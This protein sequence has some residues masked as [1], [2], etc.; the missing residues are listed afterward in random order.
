MGDWNSGYV[1][2]IG[3]TYGSYREL[4]P[5]ILSFA[6]LVAGLAAPDP[7]EQL[8]YCELGCGQG[9]SA[10]IAAAGNPH[11]EVYANDFN[12]SHILG[13]RSLAAAA[14]RG[15]VHFRDNSFAECVAETGLPAFDIIALHGIYSWISTENRQHIVEFIRT[16]LKPGGLVYISYNTLPGWSAAMPLRRLMA[17]YAG[18][19]PGSTGARVD[20]ALTYTQRLVDA[21][22][23]YFRA[24]PG[25]AEQFQ[26]IKGQN[27]SYLAHEYFNR[28]WTPFHHS[29]VV[30]EM[31]DAKLTYAG[32]AHLLDRLDVANFTQEQQDLLNTATSSTERETLRD[33]ILN[34]RFRRDIFVKGLVPLSSG[35][36]RERWKK[37]RFVLTSLRADVPL[38]V[39]G[40][41]GDATLQ[42]EFYD[43]LL[44][45]L[46]GGPRTL[47]QMMADPKV[48]AIGWGRLEQALMVLVGSG[49]LQ[50]AL[51]EAGDAERA[52]ATRS[53]NLAV[54]NKARS[55]EDLQFLA[56]PISGG[57]IHLGRISQ[58]FLLARIEAQADAPAYVWD[59]LTNAGVRLTRQDEPIETAEE[60]ME[61]LRSLLVIFNEK[62]LP[63]L[64]SVGIA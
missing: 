54:L 26:A 18:R 36:E 16:R 20:Q 27:K 58:L 52:V 51:D 28:D 3:Y 34:Q 30:A 62:Q 47:E 17:D 37:M 11:I 14:G 43:P 24:H 35:E 44:D 50:P 61:E 59:I 12:P 32:S 4:T 53:F 5:A 38:T 6:A 10:N 40:A 64:Q 39:P 13:A 1:T 31:S 60:N 2:D 19:I 25:L 21:N 23:A 33:F 55:S 46:A 15:N 22:P 45:A 49:H 7:N 41:L 57:A 63:L 48:A 8:A 56:S 29:E 9:Y 42:P